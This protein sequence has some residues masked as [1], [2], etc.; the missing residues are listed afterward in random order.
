MTIY[1]R[2]LHPRGGRF[3]DYWYLHRR[4]VWEGSLDFHRRFHPIPLGQLHSILP[5]YLEASLC[6]LVLEYSD[7]EV[8]M[9]RDSIYTPMETLSSLL[10]W[11]FPAALRST[12][13]L[14]ATPYAH[15]IGYPNRLF[16]S[17]KLDFIG[18]QF[19]LLLGPYKEAVNICLYLPREGIL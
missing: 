10:G 1:K 15:S 7:C 5:K 19:D 8:D 9:R 2:T 13:L 16:S 6:S 4:K 12:T 3:V 18:M 11:D 14:W 17:P